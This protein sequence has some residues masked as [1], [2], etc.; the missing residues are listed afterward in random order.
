MTSDE[1]QSL[2]EPFCGYVEL[3][4]DAEANDALEDLPNEI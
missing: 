3:G 2:L 4:M 1:I